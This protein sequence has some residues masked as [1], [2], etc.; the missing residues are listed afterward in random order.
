MLLTDNMHVEI[1]KQDS[2]YWNVPYDLVSDYGR[3]RKPFVLF[4]NG[5]LIIEHYDYS[6][7]EQGE[8]DIYS[9]IE[10]RI[11]LED[12]KKFK[13]GDRLVFVECGSVSI[14]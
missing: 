8:W 2:D 14:A 1:I 10:H 6:I 7:V 4:L 11:V 13:K 9:N 5:L 3:R 12:G